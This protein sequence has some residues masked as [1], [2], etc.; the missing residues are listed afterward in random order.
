VP[1]NTNEDRMKLNIEIGEIKGEL[2]DGMTE[3]EMR[4]KMLDKCKEFADGQKEGDRELHNR[5]LAM[6][7]R[8]KNTL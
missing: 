4:Q 8:A 3:D 7:L 5:K 1:I 2:P 6:K